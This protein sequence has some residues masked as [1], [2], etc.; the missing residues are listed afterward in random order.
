MLTYQTQQEKYLSFE[1]LKV[2]LY[3]PNPLLVNMENIDDDDMVKEN[4]NDLIL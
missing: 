1:D 3:L 4:F 2:D